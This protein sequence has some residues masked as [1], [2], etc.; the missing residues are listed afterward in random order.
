MLRNCRSGNKRYEQVVTRVQNI[1]YALHTLCYRTLAAHKALKASVLN[2]ITIL[3]IAAE[4]SLAALVSLGMNVLVPSTV[5]G[6]SVLM[7]RRLL[8]R[9]QRSIVSLPAIERSIEGR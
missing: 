5:T 7:A 4:L 8:H 6:K 3:S 9:S 1:Y 2:L